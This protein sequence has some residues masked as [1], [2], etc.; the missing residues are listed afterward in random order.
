MAG[1]VNVPDEDAY[2][3]YWAAAL[4]QWTTPAEPMP[5]ALPET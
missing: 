5:E 2:V 1:D 4:N 3:Q